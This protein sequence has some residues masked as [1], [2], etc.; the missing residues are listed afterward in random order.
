MKIEYKPSDGVWRRLPSDGL[1]TKEQVIGQLGLLR[2]EWPESWEYRL[3]EFP[4]LDSRNLILSR[5]AP[6]G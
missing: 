5:R 6:P 3:T 4:L 2:M 1:E